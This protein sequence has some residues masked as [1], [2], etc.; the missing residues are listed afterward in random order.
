[1][2]L[3]CYLLTVPQLSRVG[4]IQENLDLSLFP[5][6]IL[7]EV[8]IEHWVKCVLG[9][10]GQSTISRKEFKMTTPCPR[11]WPSVGRRLNWRPKHLVLCPN[12]SLLQTASQQWN[13]CLLSFLLM[14]GLQETMRSSWSSYKVSCTLHH[15]TTGKGILQN[16]ESLMQCSVSFNNFVERTLSYCTSPFP[17]N[18]S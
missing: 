5:C 18:K 10:L 11:M 8:K 7:H 16:A 17:T 9:T 3:I 6:G 14:P 4:K 12:T 1:M 2:P 15:V 13:D